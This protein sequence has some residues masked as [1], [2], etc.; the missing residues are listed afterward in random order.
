MSMLNTHVLKPETV[1]AV[2]ALGLTAEKIA[3]RWASGWKKE[4]RA[5]EASGELLPRLRAQAVREAE[6]LSNAMVG[7]ENSHLAQH[8]I[9][10]LYGISPKP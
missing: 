1:K 8:E 3:D 5:L 4:T 2:E 7:G 10:D 9:L 6:A